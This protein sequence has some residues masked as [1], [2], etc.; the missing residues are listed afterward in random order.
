MNQGRRW[1]EK[2]NLIGIIPKSIVF[3]W[4]RGVFFAVIL[5]P[6]SPFNPWIEV[7]MSNCSKIEYSTQHF[8]CGFS[9]ANVIL[10]TVSNIF[11]RCFNPTAIN[12]WFV[13]T[14]GGL[15]PRFDSKYRLGYTANMMVW[16]LKTVEIVQCRYKSI[17]MLTSCLKIIIDF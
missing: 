1:I 11:Y 13:L 7:F 17:K 12:P 15:K 3:D 8:R 9:T 6:N 10:Y 4:F 14:G 2:L 5:T 16:I